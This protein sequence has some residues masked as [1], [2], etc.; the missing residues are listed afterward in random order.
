MGKIHF[1]GSTVAI[2]S[3]LLFA[4]LL[5]KRLLAPIASQ[6]RGHSVKYRWGADGSLIVTTGDSTLSLTSSGNAKMFLQ[7]LNLPE[8]GVDAQARGTVTLRASI[9]FQSLRTYPALA[10]R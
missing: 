7:K 1:E 2:Y 3:D 6:L 9:G 10:L 5:E 8:E 4:V